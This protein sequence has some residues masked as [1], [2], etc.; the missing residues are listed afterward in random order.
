[1]RLDIRL[2][3]DELPGS[4]GVHATQVIFVFEAFAEV[5]VAGGLM[6]Q[7]W[8]IEGRQGL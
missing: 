1:M 6:A 2:H 3:I 7:S 5:K 8:D 4:A